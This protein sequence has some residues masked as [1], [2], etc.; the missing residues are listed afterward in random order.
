MCQ[1]I[2]LLLV[3]KYTKPSVELID[4]VKTLME[5]SFVS[6]REDS[7]FLLEKIH[8]EIDLKKEKPFKK[9]N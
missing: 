4:L 8:I 3:Y 7:D 9:C 6:Y 5:I 1:I 2:R